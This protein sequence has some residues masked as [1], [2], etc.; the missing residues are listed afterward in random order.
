MS[1]IRRL[2]PSKPTEATTVEWDNLDSLVAI[3]F[4]LTTL[5]KR[6]QGKGEA[7]IKC[8]DLLRTHIFPRTRELPPISYISQTVIPFKKPTSGLSKTFIIIKIR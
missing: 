1:C 6:L 3:R 8:W 2:W 7:I 5:L 4:Q